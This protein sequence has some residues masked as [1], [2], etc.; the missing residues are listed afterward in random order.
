MGALPP[1]ARFVEEAE[2]YGI[3]F[4]PGDLERLGEYLS[5]LLET[6]TRFNL[7]AVTDP[8]EAWTKHVFDSLT[9]LP[10]VV[11]AEARHVID[12]GSGGGLPGVPLA[13]ALPEVDFT[14]LEA[15]GK[16]A[17]FLRDAAGHLELANVEVINDRAETIGHDRQDHRAQYDLVVA[18]AV[19]RLVVLLELAV[20]LARVGGH[21]AAIKGAKAAREIEDAARA[22][23]LL[24]SEVTETAGTATGTIVLIQKLRRTPK[25]Y[26]RRPGEPKRAPLG[27]SKGC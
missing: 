17:D 4:D 6:N 21:V 26:P 20:P 5:L 9:L 2:A 13:I 19:G 15:T 23:H 1:P 27:I 7:T 14:L 25:L 12:V 8:E 18:R 3:A 10:Y 11:S 22:L 24:H 16:K